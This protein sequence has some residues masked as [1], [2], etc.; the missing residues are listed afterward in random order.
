[1][2]V[3]IKKLR[4]PLAA[5]LCLLIAGGA[6]A[7]WFVLRD[8]SASKL[9][10]RA[11]ASV[12]AAASA[13]LDG[14]WMVVAGTGAEATTAGY[15]V[16][17]RIAGGLVKTTATGR[18]N[19]VT[20]SVTVADRRVTAARVTVNMT[21]LKSDKSARDSVLTTM[22]IETN[23]HP[24]AAFSLTKPIALPDITPG[25]LYTVKAHGTLALHGASNPVAVTL[26][27]KQTAAGF[28]MLANVPIEMADYSI[29]APSV[30]GVVAVDDHGSFELLASL[31]KRA[32]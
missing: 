19:D 7:Y 21:T 5:T 2:K 18:T 30:A 23:T 16:Q 32:P 24:T 13:D 28:V 14:D 12:P 6:G 3:L 1:M 4:W 9:E 27:Y 25:K 22:G 31:E 8:T 10:L 26:R 15:R 20:G 29:K 17:E 11:D